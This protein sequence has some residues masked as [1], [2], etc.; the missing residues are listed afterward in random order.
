MADTSSFFGVDFATANATDI[1]RA[2][3]KPYGLDDPD[4]INGYYTQGKMNGGDAA[5]LWLK[6]TPQYDKAFPAMKMRAQNGLAPITEQ[7]Y[8][9]YKSQIT[10]T[11]RANGLPS[12][13]YDSPDDF[14]KWI[15]EF[16][17]S[18]AEVESRVT[19]GVLA[20]QQ[21]PQEVKDALFNYY[22]IDEGH[23]A[24][25]WLDPNKK[26]PELL[27]QQAATYAG[28]AAKSGGFQGLTRQEAEGV[29]AY[30]RT[31]DQLAQGFG[32]LT[33]GNQLLDALPGEDLSQM[34][35]EQQLKYVEGDQQAQEELARRANA[36]KAQFGGGGGFAQ[37]SA[38]VSGLGSQQ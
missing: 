16:D 1:I 11:L 8:T 13:F 34:T 6:G 21:A 7:Q 31:P 10:S 30:G 37:G 33:K 2:A 25:Y 29:A 23:L 27:Q 32:N 18:P 35:R 28:A 24:A 38:G 3:L 19:K 36:R 5:Y 14:A 12:G 26:G 15:G 9:Q 4:V 22:G 20:A 17:V